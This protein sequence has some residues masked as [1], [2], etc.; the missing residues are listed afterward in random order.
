LIVEV[1]ADFVATAS[2][3]A[4]G[5]HKTGNETQFRFRLRNNDFD[6]FVATGAYQ[7]QRI[8]TADGAVVIWTF[9]PVPAAEAQQT[10]AQI[11]AAAKFYSQTFGPLPKSM[12]AVYDIELPDDDSKTNISTL[13]ALEA[14]LPGVVYDW[15]F[16]PGKGF[17]TDFG[18]GISRAFGQMAL[19]F[20]WFGHMIT[21][22]PEAW[23]LGAG[24]DVYSSDGQDEKDNTGLSRND[25][26]VST[27]ED[28]DH[29]RA[30]TTEK[31]I[32]F[33]IPSD[34][35]DQLGMGGDKIRLFLF[36]L[37]D[38]CGRE[39]VEHAIAHM[40][41]ALRGQE[42]GYTDLRAALEQECR[43]DLSSMFATWLDQ[44]GIPSDFRTRYESAGV[45]K[46][47]NSQ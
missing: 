28:Y 18:N 25:E 11:A 38:R 37:E 4:R 6:P 7:Q 26:I 27:L 29:E 42:Y 24:L 10:A 3:D 35:E 31:P 21:P 41:Y 45:S 40:V 43:Q 8:T 32:T 36:A 13:E 2:G 1:P 44:K 12:K 34:P 46:Q 30:G 33:L 15:S 23:M 39:N 47:Q 16:S 14:F 19:R 5:S 22:R 9:K 17:G 20:T